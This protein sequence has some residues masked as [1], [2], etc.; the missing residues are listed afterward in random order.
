M[1]CNIDHRG[2]RVR[3]VS[4]IILVLFGLGLLTSAAGGA[5]GGVWPWAAGGAV[6]LGGGFQIFEARAGWCTLRAMG[7]RTKI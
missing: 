5:L 7:F 2:R 4:G 1:R 3:L 6:L